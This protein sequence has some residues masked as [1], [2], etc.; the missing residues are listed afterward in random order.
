[1]PHVIANQACG[2]PS[3]PAALLADATYLNAA[4]ECV[5][6]RAKT[7]RCRERLWL[8]EIPYLI[9]RKSPSGII[10]G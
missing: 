3:C 4:E 7:F 10:D 1:M 8:G 9:G 5:P 2:R 6:N